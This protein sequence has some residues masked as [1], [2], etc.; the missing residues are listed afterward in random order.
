M[1]KRFFANN[2]KNQRGAMMVELLLTVSL[3]A[4]ILPFLLNFHRDRIDRAKSIAV[5][6]EM[7]SIQTAVERY[8]DIHK[9][10]L[11]A[12]VGR[13]ITRV[14]IADLEEYGVPTA[15]I[16]KYG[17]KVQVRLLKSSDRNDRATL[18]G[19]VV[20]ND[21]EISSLRTREII[22]FGG[23]QMGFVEDGL[24]YGAFGTW[25]AS[26]SDLGISGSGGIIET[27]KT[28]LDDE[29]YLWRTPSENSADA[30]MLSALNLGSH[31]VINA[32]FMDSRVMQFEEILKSAKTVAD[33]MIFQT[34]T[35]IDNNFE[36][37]DATVAGTLS[38]DS[39]SIEVS[40][41]LTLADTARFSNFTTDHLWTNTL[42]LSGLSISSDTKDPA[43]LR[44]TQTIDMV[45]GHVS[46][47][48]VTV[49]F[50]GSV[51]P[52]LIIR[53]RIE[54]SSNPNYFWDASASAARFADV[55]VAELNRMATMIVA[56]EPGASTQS[57]QLFKTVSTN[58]NATAGDFMNAIREIQNRV[59]AKY[60]NLNLE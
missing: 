14:K 54:D 22:S 52:K 24:A 60:R 58:K 39:R 30:T 25:Q 51:T 35:T 16:E 26:V 45:G 1:T 38:A 48:Y 4:I 40:N 33:R 49:G 20:L 17:D 56:R 43:V 23:D 7:T 42:N 27:T 34:R 32:K 21:T 59:G 19:I 29:E 53:E 13:N 15:L 36:T 44:A 28:T 5:T 6:Q 55:S 18:Q 11:L 31:N 41:T 46:A 8:I 9:K 12:P 47:M 10:E 37:A 2:D 50:T 3:I 57:G